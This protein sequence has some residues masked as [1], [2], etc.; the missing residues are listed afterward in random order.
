MSYSL[1][2][3][4]AQSTKKEEKK[5]KGKKKTLFMAGHGA[6]KYGYRLL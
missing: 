6:R 5:R 2:W 3:E 4:Y 1:P